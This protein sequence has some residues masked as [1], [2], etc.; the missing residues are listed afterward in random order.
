LNGGINSVASTDI[1]LGKNVTLNAKSNL[2]A[3]VIGGAINTDGNTTVDKNGNQTTHSIDWTAALG[4]N[5]SAIYIVTQSLTTSPLLG[6]AWFNI[7]PLTAGA[8]VDIKPIIANG[9]VVITDLN[10]ANAGAY[11][12]NSVVANGRILVY[13]NSLAPNFIDLN[14][15]S[16][17]STLISAPNNSIAINVDG[18]ITKL[19]NFQITTSTM[20]LQ[21]L[22][23]N[24][25]LGGATGFPAGTGAGIVAI[26]T[27]YNSFHVHT[28][29]P[30]PDQGIIIASQVN[31]I[32]ST[33]GI[34]TAAGSEKGWNVTFFW[35]DIS[36]TNP[37][38]FVSVA[39]NTTVPVL[40]THHYEVNNSATYNVNMTVAV[41]RSISIEAHPGGVDKFF[42]SQT[43]K[44]VI[45]NNG[46]PAII[47]LYPPVPSLIVTPNVATNVVV[48][49]AVQPLINAPP[50][51]Q[52]FAAE[53][54]Q[55]QKDKYLELLLI[56]EDG[57]TPK[58]IS[59]IDGGQLK[60]KLSLDIL[61]GDQ[62]LQQFK[63]LAD[64][65][66]QL[67]L[68]RTLGG[69]ILDDRTVID[70][71]IIN[72]IPSSPV[73]ELIDQL[74]RQLERDIDTQPAA[75]PKDATTG[76]NLIP[77][78]SS[79]GAVVVDQTTKQSIDKS[80]ASVGVLGVLAGIFSKRSSGQTGSNTRKTASKLKNS[81]RTAV[82]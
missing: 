43:L 8:T 29:Y 42:E 76:I 39:G 10:G 24:Q 60:A 49:Q 80:A 18:K 30:S 71:D 37:S 52:V 78:D 51:Q 1:V 15:G 17:T 38:N 68:Y 70:T 77:A 20:F 57:S 34:K 4:S 64:G 25:V 65:R 40:N 27:D 28:P 14:V 21:Q 69:D 9:N 13:T 36:A 11:N 79:D 44:T 5:P 74:R 22:L 3:G 19:A 26:T 53:V 7:T 35:G 72:G 41:D 56:P 75:Q 62:L 81:T 6:D 82:K 50:D 31:G 55:I 61:Q 45:I 48:V 54:S 23:E 67:R 16:L 73:E 33:F 63:T 32:I 2:G 46:Q 59:L 47:F 58:V 12:L 66:Y